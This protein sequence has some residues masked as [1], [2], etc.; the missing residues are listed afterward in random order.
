MHKL[1]VFDLD[2][3][4]A[5]LGKGASAPTVRALCELER[6]GYRITVCSGKPLYYLC[7]FLRQLELAAPVLV[8]ENGG[9]LQFGISLPPARAWK[10]TPTPRAAEQLSAMR[11]RIDEVCEGRVWYQPNE[12]GLTA[13]PCIEADFA[14][15][16]A[17]LHGDAAPDELEVFHHVD[18]FDFTPRGVNK[19][20]G[21]AVLAKE[22]GLTR[23][24]FIG[25]GDGE[26]DLEM[27]AFAGVGVAMGNADEEVK[28]VADYVTTDIDDDGIWNA[29]K[30]FNLI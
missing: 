17:L 18:S 3:T 24:D 15:I 27:L 26:N 21:L 6:A 10:H 28:E 22:L 9:A 30:H 2:G 20:S 1:L 8:G 25:V 13:F 11:A 5:P 14:R 29:C 12:V 4:L 23:A 16:E 19:H 7:G